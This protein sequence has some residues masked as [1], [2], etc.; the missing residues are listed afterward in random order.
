MRL[1]YGAIAE[2]TD[3]KLLF[4][5]QLGATDIIVNTPQLP[6]NGYWEFLPLLELRTRVEAFG[7]KL[8]AIENIPHDWYLKAML[9]EQGR[10]VLIENFCKTLRNMGK[11]GIPIL[12]YHW[13][14]T[15]VWRTCYDTPWRGGARVTSFDY[16]LVKDAPL[17]PLGTLSDDQMWDNYTYFLRMVIP[18]AEEAGVR[19]GLHPDDPPVPS[20]A[21]IARIFRSVDAFKRMVEIVPSEYSGLEFCQGCFSEMGADVVE[22]IR[23]FGARKKIFYVHFRN[24]HGTPYKFNETFIDDGQT[25]MYAAMRA[26]KEVGFDGPIID[27]HVPKVVDDTPWGHR[28]RAYAS[29]Y[30]KAL[31][32]VVNALP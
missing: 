19:M 2:V 22:A 16:D 20:L 13:M 30:I 26:Y 10:D 1:A 14:P 31:I 9:G 3:E 4:A 6:G 24:V 12:G 28:G 15:A 8:A 11:A 21:G 23:Y 5:K 27:D 25:D 18:V 17:T 32:D 29:G 7:L